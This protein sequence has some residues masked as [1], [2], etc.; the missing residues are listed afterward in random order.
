MET[1]LVLRFW[2]GIIFYREDKQADC[3]EKQICPVLF[4]D[5]WIIHIQE[6]KYGAYQRDWCQ[7]DL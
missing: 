3:S 4:Y 2:D 7:K 5:G 6:V 1:L